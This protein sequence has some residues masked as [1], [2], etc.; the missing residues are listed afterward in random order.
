M[1]EGRS[2]LGRDIGLAVLA[3]AVVAAA[4]LL[5][6]IATYPNLATWYAGLTKP[7]FNPPNWIFAP[8]WTTLYVLMAF[9]LWRVLRLPRGTPGRGPALALF[10]LQLA[11]N[12]AWSWMFFAA[13]SP[14]LGL[15]NIL[16]QLCV[17]LATIG[18][19]RPLDRLAALALVP[20]AAW[21]A[22]AGVLNA[23]IWRLN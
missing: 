4:S 18:A 12:A 2:P 22:F 23:A 3:L 1:P 16:P 5:G 11:L 8:V 17:I 20:L 14:L 10:A 21:V 19:F 7:A 6:Q 9:A 15:I 13:H